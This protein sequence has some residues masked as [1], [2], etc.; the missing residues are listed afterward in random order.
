MN[1]LARGSVLGYIDMTMMARR[2]RVLGAFLFLLSALGAESAFPEAG[3]DP[4]EHAGLTDAAASAGGHA[5]GDADDHHETPGD[6]CHHHVM[7]CSCS[8]THVSS[9]AYF[10]TVL[11]IWSITRVALPS[12]SDDSAPF[13]TELLHVPIA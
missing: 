6:D 1:A 8:H 3:G 9:A 4:H 7:H 11:P 2:I 12:F 10:A 5:H 13:T